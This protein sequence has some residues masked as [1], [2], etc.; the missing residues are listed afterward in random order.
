MKIY[1]L[2]DEITEKNQS[3]VSIIEQI[4]NYQKW[5]FFKVVSHKKDNAKNKSLKNVFYLKNFLKDYL[6]YFSTLRKI[7]KNSPGTIVHIHGLWRPI[8]FF[9]LLFCKVNKIP[10]LIQ[11]H[12]MLL[13][14]ALRSNTYLNYLFKIVTLRIYNIFLRDVFFL[15][16]TKEETDS[17][18]RYFKKPNIKIIE[19]P[20][21][22]NRTSKNK[23]NKKFIYFGRINQIKNIDLVIKAFIEAK[24]PKDWVLELY[25]IQD[26][27]NYL[28][29]LKNIINNS[30]ISKQIKLKSPVFGKDKYKIIKSAWCNVLIS[31]SEILSLSV[32]ESLSV[33]TPSIVNKNIYFPNWIKKIIFLSDIETSNLKKSFQQIMDNKLSNRIIMRKK[34]IKSFDSNYS[35]LNIKK[36]YLNYI[37]SISLNINSENHIKYTPKLSKIAQI[38]VANSLNLFLLPFIV[39]LYTFNGKSEISADISIISGSIL[40]LCQVFSANARVILISNFKEKEFREFMS[41]RLLLSIIFLISFY[42]IVY[43]FPYLENYNNDLLILIILLSWLNELNLIYLETKKMFKSLILYM[44]VMFLIYSLIFLSV[45]LDNVNL[46]RDV[47]K[48]NVLFY[49]MFLIYYFNFKEKIISKINFFKILENF[50]KLALL[51]S[52]SNIIAVL[53]WRYSIYFTYDKKFAGIMIAAFSVA[54]FPGTLVNNIVGPSFVKLKLGN[55]FLKNLKYLLNFALILLVS[56][57]FLEITDKNLFYKLVHISLI[58]T[59]VLTFSIYLKNLL[60]INNSLH[61]KVFKIDILYSISIIPLIVIL[62]RINGFT[63]TSYAYL[64][65]GFISLIF[66]STLYKKYEKYI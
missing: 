13:E 9:S 47:L 63:L 21:Q 48:Y 10:F 8:Y 55:N 14:D 30:G 22:F 41:F 42:F 31:K 26:D 46:T 50:K 12:G 33:G 58:G 40:I 20:F 32:L 49:I 62:D 51:S 2:V 1:H 56:M 52:I 59:I 7:I 54:S 43:Y 66:Y 28:N 24:P 16:V 5:K 18:K 23:I 19:N 25:G 57:L 61:S 60:M 34:I 3:I 65:S 44:F 37:K 17:I 11:P 45:F 39:I 6:V 38:T 15:A 35:I 27:Q 4:S 29:F 53:I 64:V 36:K